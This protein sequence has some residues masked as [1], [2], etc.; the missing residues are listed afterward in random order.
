MRSSSFIARILLLSVLFSSVA[1]SLQLLT[2]S[3]DFYMVFVLEAE[4]E[5]ESEESKKTHDL[6]LALTSEASK[7]I[8]AVHTIPVTSVQSIVAVSLSLENPPPEV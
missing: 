4:D 6:F 8:I 3:E 1:P 5:K 2:D 7:S